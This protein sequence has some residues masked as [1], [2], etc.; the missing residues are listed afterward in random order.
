MQPT[1]AETVDALRNQYH[2]LDVIDCDRFAP[3]EIELYI[4]IKKNY[5]TAF[6]PN[7]ALIF[8]ITKDYVTHNVSGIMLRSLQKIINDIDISNAFVHLVTTNPNAIVDCK[9]VLTEVS[10][11]PEPWHIHC[12]PG[13]YQVSTA[14]VKEFYPLNMQAD[15]AFWQQLTESHK[16]KLFSNKSFCMKPWT[17]L[18][19][20]VDSRVRPCCMFE[21][22]VGDC[23]Q[24]TLQQIFHDAPMQQLREDMLA[25]HLVDSCQRCYDKENL[26]QSRDSMRLESIR[27][28]NDLIGLTD[29]SP[30]TDFELL[31]LTVAFNN[32]CN[33]ACIMCEP[34][35]STSWHAPAVHFGLVPRDHKPLL[36]AG[37]GKIDLVAQILDN[38]DQI[39]HLNFS[40]GEPL[41]SDQLYEV[42]TEIQKRGRTDLDIFIVTN[43]TK[44]SLGSSAWI[45][46]MRGLP[47]LTL[48]ASIDADGSRHEYI[49]PGA[50]WSAIIEFR[51]EL[52]REL[53]NLLFEIQPVVNLINALHLPDLHRSWVD[54]NLVQADRCRL[55]WLSSPAY[56]DV[57]HAPMALRRAIVDKYI[58]HVAWLKPLDPKGRSVVTFENVING[59]QQESDLFDAENFWQ[60]IG[61]LEQYHGS[62]LFDCFP[63][64][65]SYLTQA[66]TQ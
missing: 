33:L 42:L 59:L 46:V 58:D 31:E 29:K 28:R 40:G 35:L 2:V 52:L 50:D 54:R 60:H 11:D 49:R 1:V 36:V 6:L 22:S 23:S 18:Y 15:W 26:L 17:A 24:K 7:E 43:L 64:L 25:G 41:M 34:K 55:Q 27:D 44:R 45:D 38:L 8:L 39:D 14:D 51:S 21:G 9:E 32:L 12:V 53:P 19:V 66:R 56:L 63:E 37:K 30:T 57:R 47:K 16:T 13:S 48:Q 61:Q 10:H 4:T 62:H 20:G 65:Q 5:R 3:D